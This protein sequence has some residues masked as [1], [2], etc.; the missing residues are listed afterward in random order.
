MLSFNTTTKCHGRSRHRIRSHW[1]GR[2]MVVQVVANNTVTTFPLRRQL[3]EIEVN[4][5]VQQATTW[6]RRYRSYGR[7]AAGGSSMCQ[8]NTCPTSLLLRLS[9]Y[10]PSP[11][12][13]L[14]RPNIRQQTSMRGYC[15]RRYS[16][17][18]TWSQIC[19]DEC[20]I[21]FMRQTD[22]RIYTGTSV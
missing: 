8:C 1:T 7:N 2:T 5:H 15:R 11:K 20:K 3:S 19:E 6:R 4:E 13:K 14:N 22:K 21:A 16:N 9:N 12:I 10:W 18:K 17:P